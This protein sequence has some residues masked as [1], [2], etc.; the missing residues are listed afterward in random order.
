[1]PESPRSIK[2]SSRRNN[3]H[4]KAVSANGTIM[5]RKEEDNLKR[6]TIESGKDLDS[7]AW[8]HREREFVIREKKNPQENAAGS[9]QAGRGV[10]LWRPPARR[11]ISAPARGNPR[12]IK[13]TKKEQQLP[14]ANVASSGPNERADR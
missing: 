2:R 5:D 4:K 14:T 3:P 9:T 7:Y 12:Q 1:M 8:T 11:S 6:A 10:L 13:T